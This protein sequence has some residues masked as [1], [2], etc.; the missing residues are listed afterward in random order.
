MTIDPLEKFLSNH[1]PMEHLILS[2][3]GLGPTA[4][5]RVAS[6][7]EK[8][9]EAKSAAKNTSKLVTVKCGRNRLENGSMKAWAKLLAAHDS[10]QEFCLPQ[11]GIR[12]DGI[13]HL[14]LH[15]LS[16]STKIQKLDLQDN[17]FTV[18]GA[19]ALAQTISKWPQIKDIGISDCLLSAKGGELFG[20]ALLGLKPLFSLKN[21]R[22]QYNEIEVK[23]VEKIVQA[24]K[25]NFPNLQ[26]LE[27]NGNKFSKDDKVVNTIKVLFQQRGFGELDELDDMEIES[28][29]EL[30]ENEEDEEEEEKEKE[31]ILKQAD[32]TEAT[33]VAPEASD[34]VDSLASKLEKT[35]I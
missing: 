12:Q 27:L 14:L 26:L 23:G 2:N 21:L 22:L 11:N 3:N 35:A 33:N 1:T 20:T 4:G 18:R 10:I 9:A 31:S 17:T 15:G 32:A 19:L 8:L 5:I 13:E 34:L 28:E 25:R 24:I 6:A 29:E 30:S 7:L 16:K